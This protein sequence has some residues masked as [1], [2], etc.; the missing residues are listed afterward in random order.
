MNNAAFFAPIACNRAT[1]STWNRLRRADIRV[2]LQSFNSKRIESAI[3]SNK[4][5]GL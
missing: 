3:K 1:L 4:K 5:R 2:Y